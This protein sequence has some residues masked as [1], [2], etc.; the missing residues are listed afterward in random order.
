MPRLDSRHEH[1]SLRRHVLLFGLLAGVLITRLR[2]I[3]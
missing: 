3:D 2:L 1:G